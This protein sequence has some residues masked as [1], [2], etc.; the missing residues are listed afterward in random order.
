MSTN[1]TY[2]KDIGCF[3]CVFW[4]A[5]FAIFCILM[6]AAVDAVWEWAF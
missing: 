6:W 5:M 4:L 1:N 2:Q 3:G